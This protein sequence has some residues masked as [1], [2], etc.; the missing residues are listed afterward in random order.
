MFVKRTLLFLEKLRPVHGCLPSSGSP[1]QDGGSEPTS[2]KSCWDVPA[3][4]LLEDEP[5]SIISATLGAAQPF[6]LLCS[7]NVG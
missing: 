7:R 5:A 3:R 6:P 1:D 2:I 4:Q